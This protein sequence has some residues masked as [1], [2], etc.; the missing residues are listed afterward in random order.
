MP[1]RGEGVVDGRAWVV[2]PS[3]RRMD[4]LYVPGQWAR[5]RIRAVGS[6]VDVFINGELTAS[7]R[8][9]PGR[10][11]GH[12]GLQLHG[13]QDMHVEYRSLELLDLSMPGR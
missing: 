12:L 10:T 4:G 2:K 1:A 5:L 9:D 8:D 11:E 7:L 3:Q 6:D 13:G